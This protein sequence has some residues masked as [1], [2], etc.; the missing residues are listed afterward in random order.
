M[1]R[2]RRHRQ[3]S[4]LRTEQQKRLAL[5]LESGNSRHERVRVTRAFRAVDNVDPVAREPDAF[6]ERAHFRVD[7]TVGRE[8][9]K[10]VEQGHDDVRS[11]RDHDDDEH[12]REPED[13]GEE[14]EDGVVPDP[15]DEG[16]ECRR[17]RYLES[18][19]QS[20]TLKR[21]RETS[22]HQRRGVR[23]GKKRDRR[24]L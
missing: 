5:F 7:G 23:D 18:K 6:G 3:G 12:G 24:N 14:A 15:S 19:G 11:E 8:E 4:F 2:G 17:E 22:V 10:L 13:P 1:K 9:G 16:D 21:E 20:E